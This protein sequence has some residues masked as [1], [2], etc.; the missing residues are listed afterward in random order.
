MHWLGKFRNGT[1]FDEGTERLGRPLEFTLGEAEGVTFNKIVPV[2]PFRPLS[3]AERRVFPAG[4]GAAEDRDALLISPCI[5]QGWH[6][7]LEGMCL[8]EQRRL[9]VPPEMAYASP[10]PDGTALSLVFDIELVMVN[11][12]RSLTLPPRKVRRAGIVQLGRFLGS[13]SPG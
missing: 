11:G 10:P 6:V 3:A 1:V 7:G 2:R 12:Q 9:V 5:V 13:L 8:K 4:A